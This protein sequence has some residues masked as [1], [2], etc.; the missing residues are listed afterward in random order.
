MEKKTD[1][2]HIKGELHALGILSETPL[3]NGFEFH[4]SGIPFELVFNYTYDS[5]SGLSGTL[6]HLSKVDENCDPFIM[7]LAVED[8]GHNSG[9]WVTYLE[10]RRQIGFYSFP[11]VLHPNKE[12]IDLSE[13]IQAILE[14]RKEI[15]ERY[16]SMI[17]LVHLS[18]EEG[19]NPPGDILLPEEDHLKACEAFPFWGPT[20]CTEDIE[21]ILNKMGMEYEVVDLIDD[22]KPMKPILFWSDS[23]IYL[24]QE[25]SN[26]LTLYTK[27]IIDPDRIDLFGP[28]C[29]RIADIIA[30]SEY[31]IEHNVCT[32]LVRLPEDT[33]YDNIGDR[34]RICVARLNQFIEQLAEDT[35]EARK[36]DVTFEQMKMY[37]TYEVIREDLAEDR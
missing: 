37:F 35:Q 19:L 25:D 5:E 12:E 36:I 33:G 10:D 4:V 27:M 20:L 9:R 34:L 21:E 32:V 23:E 17:Q 6:V 15:Q 18:I 31:R 13:S 16:L 11:T 29:R 2:E 26:R 30:R 14:C 7:H 22:I 24:I 28:T 1:F 8:T 3:D